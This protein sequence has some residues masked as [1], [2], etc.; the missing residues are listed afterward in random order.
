M[1]QS[2]NRLTLGFGSGLGL[3]VREFESHFGPRTGME[4]AWDSLYSSFSAPSPA[5]SLCLSVSLSLK[6]NKLKKK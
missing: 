4:S 2:V 3:T 5:H 6:I 1:V